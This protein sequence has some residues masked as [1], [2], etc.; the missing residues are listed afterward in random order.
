M[1]STSGALSFDTHIMVVVIEPPF[2]SGGCL[3]F[4]MKQN[5][6]NF[7]FTRTKAATKFPINLST[8][9]ESNFNCLKGA[10]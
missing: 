1:C 5:L 9:K 3:G 2:C 8:G 7:I 10:K 4:T 6:F